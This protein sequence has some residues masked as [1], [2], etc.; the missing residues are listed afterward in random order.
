MVSPVEGYDLNKIV[1]NHADQS[2]LQVLL[3]KHADAFA[4]YKLD[5]GCMAVTS[6]VEGEDISAQRQNPYPEQANPY[7][8]KTIKFLLTQGVLSKCTSTANSPLGP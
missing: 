6:V 8:E 5:C 7:I 1:A 2:E 4:K 3:C